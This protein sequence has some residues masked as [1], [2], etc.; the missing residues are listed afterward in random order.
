MSSKFT[1][2][3]SSA[4]SANIKTNGITQEFIR[5]LSNTSRDQPQTLE[6]H[7]EILFI[8][9]YSRDQV[10]KCLMSELTD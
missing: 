4:L 10:Y 1:I 3:V 8:S 7:I 6:D 5:R 2:V 9:G